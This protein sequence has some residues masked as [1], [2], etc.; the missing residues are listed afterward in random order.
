[1][2]FTDVTAFNWVEI[3]A[4]Y[5]GSAT[6]ALGVQLEITPFDGSAWHEYHHIRHQTSTEQSMENYSFF[7][8][9][10]S[11]YINSGTV[12][13]R[14]QHLGSEVTN[15]EWHIDSVALYQ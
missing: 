2:I 4:Y 15:H 13:I 5:D 7:I 6:H 14:F 12:T 1:M 11:A 10:D 9:D 8:P 3:L